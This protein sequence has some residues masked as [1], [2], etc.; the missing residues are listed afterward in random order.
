MR[1]IV[2]HALAGPLALLILEFIARGRFDAAKEHPEDA[3]HFSMLIYYIT[4]NDFSLANAYAF[5]ARWFFFNIAA[6]EPGVHNANPAIGYGGDFNVSL[7][8]YFTSLAAGAA[9]LLMLALIAAS[10][11][12]RFR[13]TMTRGT[14]GIMLGLL[15]YILLRGAFFFIFLPSEALLFASSVS[16]AVLLLIAIPFAASQFPRKRV[17]LALFATALFL[18]NGAFMLAPQP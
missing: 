6:P 3:T 11:W 17:L 2:L 12:P 4:K 14:A 5:V 18:A 8:G 16:F 1:W 10:L 7:L 13:A 9:F 15:A